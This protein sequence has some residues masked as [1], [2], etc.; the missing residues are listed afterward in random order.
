MIL[1]TRIGGTLAAQLW[2]LWLSNALCTAEPVRVAHST[3][4]PPFAELKDGKSQGLAIDIVRAATGRVRIEMEFIAVP[5]EQMEQT[6][7]D[8]RADALLQAPNSERLKLLDFSAPVL[9]TGGALYVRSPNPT[10]DDLLAMSGKVVVTPQAGPL[11]AIISRSAPAVKL[12]V[13]TDYEQSLARL[14]D[15]TADAAALNYHVGGTLADRLYPGQVTKPNGMFWETPLAISVLKGRHGDLLER[16][17][18]GLAAIRADGT[19]Q[20]INA[21]WVAQ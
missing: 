2:C 12:S 7:R 9:I 20:Q 15:G 18:K 10:P 14:V 21:R 17:N 19:W 13:T 6:L 5:I 4:F 8:G 3:P 1:A 16:L 11:V